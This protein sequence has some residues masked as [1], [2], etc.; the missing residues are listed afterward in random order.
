MESV[1]EGMQESVKIWI[2]LIMISGG[3]LYL[4]KTSWRILAWEMVHSELKLVKAMNERIMVE[5]GK[6]AYTVID[7]KSPDEANEGLGYPICPDW[8]KEHAHEAILTSM[9][10]LCGRTISSAQLTEQEARQALYQR[11]IPKLE[12]KMRLTSLT[13]K[14][15]QPINTM[16]RQAIL[17]T[18]RL[19][20]GMPDA[21]VF[22]TVNH[23]GMEFPEAYAL[24]D[25]LQI[26]DVIRQLR[27]DKTVAHDILV[28]LDNIQLYAGYVIHIMKDTQPRMDYVDHGLLA[29]L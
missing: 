21:V 6:G 19:N 24:Q 7:F 2:N 5:Y 13:K 12:Y 23:G 16:N 27:W 26:T 22:G 1:I 4:H 14:Q 20:R 3:S 15:C 29:S 11:L 18:M 17:P 9:R 10:K 8:N 25:Q 28:T